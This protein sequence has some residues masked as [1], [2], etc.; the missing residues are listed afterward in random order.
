MTLSFYTAT[1][2][3]CYSHD[4]HWDDTAKTKGAETWRMSVVIRS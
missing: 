1:I 2:R 4:L 3:G